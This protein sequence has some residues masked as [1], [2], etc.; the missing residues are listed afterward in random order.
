[1]TERELQ[2]YCREKG[3]TFFNGEVVL[4]DRPNAGRL[5]YLYW[6]TGNKIIA[7]PTDKLAWESAYNGTVLAILPDGDCRINV[8]DLYPT[9][10]EAFGGATLTLKDEFFGAILRLKRCRNMAGKGAQACLKKIGMAYNVMLE[11]GVEIH[12]IKSYLNAI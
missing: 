9:R 10:E 7:I 12:P 4:P 11:M 8:G 2:S 3:T 1:M 5:S 6:F